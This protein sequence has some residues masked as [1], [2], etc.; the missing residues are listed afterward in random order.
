M[1]ALSVDNLLHH[2]DTTNR[3]SHTGFPAAALARWESSVHV[4]A[5]PEHWRVG[6]SLPGID[7]GRIHLTTTAHLVT[8]AITSPNGAPSARRKLRIPTHL[9]TS[10]MTARYRYG[11]LE[12]TIPIQGSYQARRVE[13]AGFEA[14]PPQVAAA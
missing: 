10:R 7:P 11:V 2:I 3:A 14:A 6:L 9:D 8:L 4:E 13:I 12:L 5:M 1:T